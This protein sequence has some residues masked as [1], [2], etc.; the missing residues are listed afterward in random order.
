MSKKITI[1]KLKCK[2]CDHEWVPRIST[3]IRCAK[4]KHPSWDTK[5][6]QKKSL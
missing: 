5:K 4:C 6:T 1:K 2:R 3:I